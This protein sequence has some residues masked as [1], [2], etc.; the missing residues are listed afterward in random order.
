MEASDIWVLALALI[1]PALILWG[2][3]LAR[4]GRSGRPSVIL[5]IPQ[6]LRP[7]APDEVLEGP[8]LE[9]IQVWWLI[10]LAALAL[11]IPA[12]WLSEIQRQ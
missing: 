2:V 3:Y 7:G 12:Y 6:A 8:R 1:V 9:R 11:F 10:S 4:S 5:G